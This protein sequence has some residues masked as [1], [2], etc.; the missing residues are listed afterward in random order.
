M[1]WK[2]AITLHKGGV[3]NT[4]TTTNTTTTNTASNTAGYAS[5]VSLS[6]PQSGE[7]TADHRRWADG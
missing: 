5:P 6:P 1:V 7:R 3:G 2:F 4:T